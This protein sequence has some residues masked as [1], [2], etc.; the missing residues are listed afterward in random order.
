MAAWRGHRSWRWVDLSAT[1]TAEQ[2]VLG[3]R[4]AGCH[5][6]HKSGTV[7]LKNFPAPKCQQRPWSHAAA[8]EC[9]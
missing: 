3:G 7:P 8:K 2:L 5:M 1:V 4:G 6:P 9:Q